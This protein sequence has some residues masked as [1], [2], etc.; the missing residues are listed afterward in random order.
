MLLGISG[1]SVASG[2][3][4][5]DEAPNFDVAAVDD[6]RVSLAA[7]N[8]EKPVYLKFWLSTCPQCI[9]EMPHFV[10]SF[11]QYGD[12]M[13]FVAVNLA[14]DE[15]MQTLE[16]A[17]ST[18]G[19]DMPVVFDESREM[20]TKFGVY[21]TPTHIVIDRNGRVV[22]RSNIANDKL[23]TAIDCVSRDTIL[24]D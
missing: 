21:G 11:E 9:A 23:D 3:D 15:T 18:H 14:M 10:H 7:L 16:Q 6:S 8:G 19:L 22:H 4:D 1:A 5:C 17:M 13:A 12:R 20:Q 24:R 2:S